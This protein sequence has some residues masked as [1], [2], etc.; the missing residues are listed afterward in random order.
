[1]KIKLLFVGLLIPIAVFA[2]EPI[3]TTKCIKGQLFAV[4]TMSDVSGVAVSITQVFIKHPNR[5]YRYTPMTCSI[6]DG[7]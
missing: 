1:M 7:K 5:E 6:K 4:A 3:I 2:K